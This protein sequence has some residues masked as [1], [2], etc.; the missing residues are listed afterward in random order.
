[1]SNKV[2]PVPDGYHA[3]T[4]Y[5]ICKN[6]ARAIEFYKK[7]FGATELSRM[8]GP[9]EQ[10]MH[11][12]I[13]I[14]DSR[15]MLSDEFPDFEALG[16]QSRGGTTVSFLLYVEDAGAATERAVAAG[17]KLERPVEDQFYGDRTGTVVDPFG[18]KWTLATHFEDVSDEEMQRRTAAAFGE[19]T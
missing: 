3:V 1:M 7:A 4:P 11:A 12:E 14:R 15:I 10:V 2:K 18:H 13:Q 16:P 8:Q 19:K 5:L 6:A 17:A 9:N